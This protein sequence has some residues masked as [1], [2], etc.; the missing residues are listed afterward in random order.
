M[1]MGSIILQAADKRI[2]MPNS[3]FMIHFGSGG[4]Y[5]HAK[6]TEKWADESKRI[7]WEMENIYIEKLLAIDKLKGGTYL[8]DKINQI[9]KEVSKYEIPTKRAPFKISKTDKTED[10]RTALQFMLNFD[11]ILTPQQTIDLGFADEIHT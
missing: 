1:S 8:E 9:I 4:K 6:I 7:C 11:T 10:I 5:S 3:R 2:M